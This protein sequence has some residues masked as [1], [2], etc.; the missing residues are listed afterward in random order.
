MSTK[1]AL[2]NSLGLESA[3]EQARP[4]LEKVQKGFQFI[5]NL[6]GTFANSPAL[7]EAYMVLDSAFE[8][9]RLS[10][11]ERQLVLLAA[12]VENAC[13][14]C[15]AAHSTVLKQF[16][17]VPP[18]VVVAVRSGSPVSDHKLN[19]LVNLTKEIVG[20]RGYVDQQTIDSFLAAGY[21]KE[22]V[23]EVLIG[24]ALKTISNY[25]NHLSPNELDE[26][27]AVER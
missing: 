5:P 27:F 23:L 21:Q 16:L 20:A 1:T 17:K 2:F 18:E 12:S 22:Q 10:P 26:A 8:K 13:Q 11:T 9:T 6:Y 7:L 19:A 24:V 4:I 14:Y 15:T 3:S 25:T